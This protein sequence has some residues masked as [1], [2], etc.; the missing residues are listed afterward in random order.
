MI[1]GEWKDGKL[2]GKAIMDYFGDRSA[3]YEVK[4]GKVDGKG[5]WKN[6]ENGDVTWIEY[7]EGLM[8]GARRVNHYP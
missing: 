5:I 4:N 8:H 6:S 1:E 3:Y 2:D 7:K